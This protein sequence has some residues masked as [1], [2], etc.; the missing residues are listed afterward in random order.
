MA[1]KAVEMTVMAL[2]A[3]GPKLLRAKYPDPASKKQLPRLQAA[4]DENH[5]G[6]NDPHQSG[7]AL[8]IV[9][10]SANETERAMAD[11]LVGIFLDLRE[12][13]K[14][15]AVIYNRKQWDSAG[16]QSERIWKKGMKSDPYGFEH[17]SHI[18]IEWPKNKADLGDFW[19]S[20]TE[21]CRKEEFS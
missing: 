9:L 6:E 21:T 20:L 10:F 8:D 12:E 14:W 18:H 7:R 2:Q 1:K 16:K 3:Y 11:R 17:L 15:G 4:P 13:M 5:V 19:L